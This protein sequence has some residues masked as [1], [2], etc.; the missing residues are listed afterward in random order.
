MAQT[1]PH[2]SYSALTHEFSSKIVY[3]CHTTSGVCECIH[4]L[5][6][7]LRI[8]LIPVLSGRNAINDSV[9][10]LLSLLALL[11]GLGL[12]NPIRKADTQYND[13]V[14]I[15]SPIVESTVYLQE[16]KFQFLHFHLSYWYK[17]QSKIK[18]LS[19]C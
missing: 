12:T 3:L 11:R 5:V 7:C 15:L 18:P 16:I 10:S 1:Q 4:P 19:S 13:S 9:H 6:D 8:R 14:L 2:A 17:K